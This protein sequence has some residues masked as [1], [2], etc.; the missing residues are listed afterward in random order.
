MEDDILLC[1]NYASDILMEETDDYVSENNEYEE[2]LKA[3]LLIKNAHKI[4]E[5]SLMISGSFFGDTTINLNAVGDIDVCLPYD[6]IFDEEHLPK[7]IREKI[8]KEKLKKE[9]QKNQKYLKIPFHEAKQISNEIINKISEIN[10][11]DVAVEISPLNSLK[12]NI[13]TD[14]ETLITIIKPFKELVDLKKDE[15]IF[16]IYIND[17]CII[18]NAENLYELVDNIKKIEN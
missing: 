7:L 10:F 4:L 12:L 9:F 1:E 5:K 6:F 18:S 16:N 2:R 14:Q 15:V 11:D 17:E 13:R 3:F 8:I